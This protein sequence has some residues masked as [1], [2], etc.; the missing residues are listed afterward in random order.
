M[1]EYGNFTRFAFLHERL[2]RLVDQNGV[3]FGAFICRPIRLPLVKGASKPWMNILYDV[4]CGIRTPLGH[5]LLGV[6]GVGDGR[7]DVCKMS[8][9]FFFSIL[10]L[11]RGVCA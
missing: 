8:T 9:H 6:Y 5:P 3:L 1:D 2:G 7:F 10:Y 4:L 11:T